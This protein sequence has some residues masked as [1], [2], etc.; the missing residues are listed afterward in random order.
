[1]RDRGVSSA[2]NYVLALG[3]VALLVSGLFVGMSG[4]VEE[5]REGAVRSELTVVGNRL[6]TDVGTAERLALTGDA[7]TV[8]LSVSLPDRVSGTHYL[9]NVTWSAPEQYLLVLRAPAADVSTTAHLR[10]RVRIDQTTVSGGELR[11]SYDP[12]TDRLEVANA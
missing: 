3:I 1:M 11:I 8:R 5:R 7:R 10:S 6:A 9:V 2:L 12:A 4:F